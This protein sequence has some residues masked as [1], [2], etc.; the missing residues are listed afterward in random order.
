MMSLGHSSLTSGTYSR[1][2]SYRETAAPSMT[3]PDM[4]GGMSGRSRTEKVS[5]PGGDAHE[6]PIR[7]RPESCRPATKTVPSGS[8]AVLRI[9]ASWV[10]PTSSQYR[11]RRPILPAPMPARVSGRARACGPVI[12]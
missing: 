6:R 10:D 7:P 1:M 3:M 11:T 4:A 8:P 2:V 9:R 12:N 5:V